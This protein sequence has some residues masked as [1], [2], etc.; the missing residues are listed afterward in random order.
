MPYRSEVNDNVSSY[1]NRKGC[2]AIVVLAGCDSNTKFHMFCANNTGST[3]DCTAWQRCQLKKI[4]DEGQL[5]EGSYIIGDEVFSCDNQLLT[6]WSGVAIRIPKDTFNFHLS[7]RRQTI[8]RAFGIL[9]R[10]WG[11]FWRDV[12]ICHSKWALLAT[13]CAKL[14]NYCIDSN[15]KQKENNNTNNNNAIPLLP[16]T[17]HPS[18]IQAGDTAADVYFNDNMDVIQ[19]NNPKQATADTGRRRKQ[20]D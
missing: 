10:R 19:E 13:V 5:P 4:I 16:V 18:N 12:N 8:E 15:L 6:P 1:R 7:V 2:F 14:H 20:I 17:M 9:T 3:N 11:V